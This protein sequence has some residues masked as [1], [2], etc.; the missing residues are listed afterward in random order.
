MPIAYLNTIISRALLEDWNVYGKIMV[1]S[2]GRDSVAGRVS[3]PSPVRPR[4]ASSAKD[5]TSPTRSTW[6]H[7]LWL[8]PRLCFHF[9]LTLTEYLE[10]NGQRG[11]GPVALWTESFYTAESKGP[12]SPSSLTRRT[13]TPPTTASSSTNTSSVRRCGSSQSRKTGQQAIPFSRRRKI[14]RHDTKRHDGDHLGREA[15]LPADAIP[16]AAVVTSDVHGSNRIIGFVGSD[17]VFSW[18]I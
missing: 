6:L 18:F 9:C 4:C 14:I 2:D 1:A 15:P 16:S 5:S 7:N 3:G 13:E 8:L 10:T 12:C 11:Q 17:H